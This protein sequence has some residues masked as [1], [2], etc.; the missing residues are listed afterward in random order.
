LGS[1]GTAL[2]LAAEELAALLDGEDAAGCA[3]GARG[4]QEAERR[5]KKK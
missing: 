3:G 5:K 4:K 2:D 1:G